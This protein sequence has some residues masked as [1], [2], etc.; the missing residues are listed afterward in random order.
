MLSNW[1]Q[2]RV[3]QIDVRVDEGDLKQITRINNEQLIAA[4]EAKV[5]EATRKLQETAI[6]LSLFYRD[7]TGQPI[8]PN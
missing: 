6:K 3:E 5:I 1:R 8:M 7:V 2:T 4:R